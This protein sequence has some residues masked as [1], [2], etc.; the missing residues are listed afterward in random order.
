ML[1]FLTRRMHPA[2]APE[3]N[4]QSR[5]RLAS[6]HRRIGRQLWMRREDTLAIECHMRR[7][8]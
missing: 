7:S 4:R 6:Q 2:P 3:P 5:R 1:A 8:D